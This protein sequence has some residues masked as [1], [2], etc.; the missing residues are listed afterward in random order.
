MRRGSLKSRIFHL[1]KRRRKEK[2]E[3]TTSNP[4]EDNNGRTCNS[5]TPPNGTP[6]V[7]Q[8]AQGVQTPVLSTRSFNHGGKVTPP[9]GHSLLPRAAQDLKRAP[10]GQGNGQGVTHKGPVNER[11]GNACT[12]TAKRMNGLELH[13]NI[14]MEKLHKK[15]DDHGSPPLFHTF[16]I[17]IL[18]NSR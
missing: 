14:T 12:N 17:K 4:V 11:N 18:W 9:S 1:S 13:C 16:S 6:L 5:K 2:H 15:L 7:S 10:N 8:T 3:A